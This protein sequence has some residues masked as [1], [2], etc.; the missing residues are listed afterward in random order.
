M[1]RALFAPRCAH[2]ESTEKNFCPAGG[3]Q[4]TYGLIHLLDPKPDSCV[5]LVRYKYPPIRSENPTNPDSD[6]GKWI[7]PSDSVIE[8][9]FVLGAICI[10]NWQPVI[11]PIKESLTQSVVIFLF[12]SVIV[13][14]SY[15]SI[16][17]FSLMVDCAA[18][19]V[20]MKH[21]YHLALSY[22]YTLTYV[23]KIHHWAWH[24]CRARDASIIFSKP[25]LL[26]F[27]PQ[28]SPVL[29]I[30]WLNSR[31]LVT[32]SICLYPPTFYQNFFP[33][34]IPSK[35]Y[36]KQASFFYMGL[37]WFSRHGCIT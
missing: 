24:E 13:C 15:E 20:P 11:T 14:S 17:T 3:R 2:W 23:Y 34:Y 10:H 9:G 29:L 32:Q 5:W 33:K 6:S 27:I 28:V 7:S 31:L 12:W 16:S 22:Q 8:T 37:L 36:F 21:T 18:S 30:Q 26:F 19:C 35:S 1:L 25:L 4:K